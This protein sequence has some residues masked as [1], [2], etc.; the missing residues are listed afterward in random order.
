MGT[1]TSSAVS[2]QT[3]L[4]GRNEAYDTYFIFF[5]LDADDAN[6]H[7]VN[8]HMLQARLR[9]IAASSSEVSNEIIA[10]DWAT[11]W[12]VDKMFPVWSTESND[13]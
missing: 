9:R 3:V 2:E 10:W 7:I 13:T 8:G 5:T 4:T 11:T 1:T 12:C 6:N